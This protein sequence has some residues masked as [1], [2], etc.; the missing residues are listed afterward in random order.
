MR[1]NPEKDMSE[2]FLERERETLSRYAFLTAN[3]KG[4]DH[5]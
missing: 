5:P 4:R 3:T 2:I 1:Y